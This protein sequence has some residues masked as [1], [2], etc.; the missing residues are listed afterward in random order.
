MLVIGLGNCLITVHWNTSRRWKNTV[1]GPRTVVVSTILCKPLCIHFH[2]MGMTA[3]NNTLYCNDFTPV[4]Y[5]YVD[6][7]IPLG[8]CVLS[9]VV[10]LCVKVTKAWMDAKRDLTSRTLVA[11]LLSFPVSS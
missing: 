5:E 1:L 10:L 6:L 11:C 7:G 9:L 2:D 4:V 8:S 3:S